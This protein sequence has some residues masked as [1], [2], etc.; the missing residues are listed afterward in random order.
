MPGDPVFHAKAMASVLVDVAFK[1]DA[2]ISQRGDEEERVIHG[3]APVFPRVPDEAGRGRGGDVILGGELGAEGFRGVR[4]EQVVTRAAMR[5]GFHRDHRIAQDSEV[6]PRAE[7]FDGIRGVRVSVVPFGK[8]RGGE[9]PACGGADNDDL[10][11]VETVCGRARPDEAQRAGGIGQHHG[12]PVAIAAE[13]VVE[14]EG[15]EPVKLE[16]ARKPFALLGGEHA[17]SAAGENQYRSI[18]KIGAEWLV[19]IERGDVGSGAAFCVGR[20]ALPERDGLH[21]DS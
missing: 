19:D 14:D 8:E 16:D 18:R 4:A 3:H 17:V 15:F 5:G 1:R 10:V 20:G 13:P 12:M 6:G 21:G 2:G 9:V 7:P 11:R